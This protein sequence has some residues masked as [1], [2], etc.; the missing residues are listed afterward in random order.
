MAFCAS[1]GKE[2]DEGGKF[3]IHCGTPVASTAGGEEGGSGAVDPYKTVVKG[4]P[5]YGRVNLEQLPVGHVIDDRYEV[6]AKL[7]QGGFGAVYRV[8]DRKMECDKA[9]KVLPEA[10]AS[11]IEAMASIR[12]EAVTM[13]KLNHPNIVRIFEFQDQGAIKYIDMEFVDGK[14]L[15]EIKVDASEK[16]LT[17]EEVAAFGAGIARGLA[18][19]HGQGVIHK[20]IKPQNILIAT[21]G[22]PKVTDFG[23]SETVKSSMSRIANS[24]SSGTLLYM[25]PEQVRGRDVGRE[26]DIYSFGALL[27]EL[28]CGHPPFHKGAIEHQILNE[29]V[30]PLEGISAPMNTLVLKC[31]EKEYTARFRRFEEVLAALEGKEVPA[32]S[33]PA[34]AP[35]PN[36]QGTKG[37]TPFGIVAVVV[38]VIAMAA[39]GFALMGGGESPS[40]EEPLTPG[41]DTVQTTTDLAELSFPERQDLKIAACRKEITLLTSAVSSMKARMDS[42][43]PAEGDSMKAML[44]LIK[45]KTTKTDAL[46]VLIEKKDAWSRKSLEEDIATYKGLVATEEGRS[47]QA[48]AWNELIEKYPERSEGAVAYDTDALL[49]GC[50]LYVEAEPRGAEVRITNIRPAFF[51]GIRL[52]PGRYDISATHDGYIPESSSVM[53]TEGGGEMRVSLRLEPYAS[54]TVTTQPEDARII[55]KGIKEKYSPGVQ[56]KAGTYKVFVTAENH[57]PVE[58]EVTLKAGQAESL[59]FD[60]VPLP[61]LYVTTSPEHARVRIDGI[62]ASYAPGMRLKP[63]Q[64][65]VVA[66]A[67]T[68][69]GAS[70]LVTLGET[71]KTELHLALEKNTGDCLFPMNGITLGVSTVK[72]LRAAGVQCKSIDDDTGKPYLYYTV[73]GIDFWYDKE[74]G[75]VD[76]LPFSKGDTLHDSL[77]AMGFDHDKSYNDWL[78]VLKKSGFEVT[79]TKKPT[80]GSYKGKK[81]LKAELKGT[82]TTLCG[83]EIKIKL[84][85]SWG[86]GR[87]VTDRKTLNGIYIW[88]KKV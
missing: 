84:D 36:G 82:K 47:L 24:S 12:K 51:P 80:T 21:D 85:F 87:R 44:G 41:M 76:Y 13:A 1:C 52:T 56:L 79:V 60:L 66:S 29:P 31:L 17:E 27:Y 14:S 46:A 74:S 25:A 16:R 28:L 40:A 49:D 70:R 2:L 35:V 32:A 4:A 11:D 71:G 53:I 59:A 42:G 18:Y 64:Y 37:K 45:E 65:K 54:M 19:A 61:R 86:K 48:A 81:W 10:V 30:P 34:G 62:E 88:G 33:S 20:D 58:R 5:A 8:H 6:K 67:K 57:M 23:I 50:R 77:V 26:S 72:D 43:Q 55:L 83:T 68:Y 63:G 75:V 39:G 69:K 3:C 9:L 15:T 73:D 22:T 38:A 7:G 78:E